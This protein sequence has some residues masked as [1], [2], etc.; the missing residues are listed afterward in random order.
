MEEM[1]AILVSDMCGEGGG[2]SF[3]FAVF[4]NRAMVLCICYL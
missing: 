1:E 3:L 2:V 4:L